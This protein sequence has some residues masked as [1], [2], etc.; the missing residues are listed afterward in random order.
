VAVSSARGA[1]F[2]LAA[3]SLSCSGCPSAPKVVVY[4]LV[5]RA[6]VAEL[7][8]SREVLRF[9]TPATEPYLA[10]GFFQEA[11][12]GLAAAY[13]W[14]RI[15]C[16]LAFNW[17]NAVTRAAV[18]D[19]APFRGV[20][21]QQARVM[22]NGQLVGTLV[23]D[24][25][26]RQRLELPAAAQR[27]GDNRLKFY[28]SASA[29]PH[30]QDAAST[31][32][33]QLSAAFYTM[34][35]GPD[36]DPVLMDLLARD[37]PEVLASATEGGVPQLTQVGDSTVRYTL[38]LPE[39]AELRFTPDLQRSARAAGGSATFRVTLDE[40]RDGKGA[41]EIWS[42]TISAKD[43]K[44]G[45]VAVRLT[46][47]GEAVARLALQVTGSRF[48]WGVWGSPRVLG[49]RAADLLATPA[50]TP[51]ERKGGDAVR[52]ALGKVNVVFVILDAGRAR[53]FGCY[54]YGRATTPNIDAIAKD[55]V[56]FESVFTP[57]VYTL[58]AM[59]SV[60]TSQYAE[61]HHSAVS[62]SSKLPKDHLVLSELLSAQGIYTAGFVANTIAGKFN[63]F[64]R[65]FS[66]F[67][68]VYKEQ[69]TSGAD[70][71]GRVL[72]QWLAAHKDRPFFAYVHFREPHFPYDPPPPFDTKFGPEGPLPKD[73]RRDNKYVNDDLNQERRKPAPDEIEHIVRLYDGNL[74][75][76]DQEI[77]RLREAL[78]KEGLWDRT[79]FI[80]AADHGEQ[81]F[82]HGWLGHNVQLYDDST[83]VPLV[84]HFPAGKGPAGVRVP[85]FADLLDVAP[86][87]AD[88]FGVLGKAGSDRS[89]EGRSLLPVIAGAPGKTAVLSRTIWDRPR[90]ALRTADRKYVYDTRSGEDSLFDLKADPGE[91]HDRKADEPLLA[92]YYRETLFATIAR[93]ARHEGG[94]TA[95]A[96]DSKMTCEECQNLKAL[97]YI[98]AVC[99][100]P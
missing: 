46:S 17:P 27:P 51:E 35:V 52:D 59:S 18:V 60:W 48:A 44:P 3:V 2:L 86:T 19:L 47:G 29:S 61:R 67:H 11:A 54:G 83:H 77:G 50:F 87:I 39:R 78:Q 96:A 75:F 89:F 5:S 56:L 9:G 45:E 65:G 6:S 10:D 95:A 81:L 38:H 14:S 34:V 43:P 28:F 55:S 100:C 33:R 93:L 73:K 7:S 22:L 76:A 16:E 79:V 30:D 98:D 92:A 66:E 13:V 36:D 94:G 23:V 57:A 15:D 4:D 37:A 71:F 85:G 8:S 74:A 1:A 12:G 68:E 53:E 88:L 32:T 21:G 63:G 97:G 80:V 72:P 49:R 25:H 40:S 31:D 26:R 20:T 99:P 24:T 70:G 62:S 64:D 42:R 91:Q 84:V 82:E 69:A 41:R 58:G 90:Y